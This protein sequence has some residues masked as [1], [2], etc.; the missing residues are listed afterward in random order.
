MEPEADLTECQSWYE[1]TRRAL[2]A[3]WG[4]RSALK[5]AKKVAVAAHKRR[6]RQTNEV[7]GQAVSNIVRSMNREAAAAEQ[8]QAP[9]DV[10]GW[11]VWND[12]AAADAHAAAAAPASVAA[13]AAG[14]ISPVPPPAPAPA[15][16]PSP[17]PPPAP[18]LARDLAAAEE[19]IEG[20]KHAM[21]RQREHFDCQLITQQQQQQQQQQQ[22]VDRIAAL[23]VCAV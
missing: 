14:A 18:T 20:L 10:G 17:P 13:A 9:D 1:A 7:A 5:N 23:E 6:F 15:P 21:R 8:V 2:T 4:D 16:A 19:C 22:I 11:N 3:A 12:D